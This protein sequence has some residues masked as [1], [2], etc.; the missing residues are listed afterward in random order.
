MPPRSPTATMGSASA[1][2]AP[3]SCEVKRED[4]VD[5]ETGFEPGT[6]RFSR[7]RAVARFGDKRLQISLL[8]VV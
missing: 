5:G 3:I 1:P 6:P 2:R 4:L 8:I 7:S